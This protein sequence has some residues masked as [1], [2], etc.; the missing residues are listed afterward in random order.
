MMTKETADTVTSL[1]F[2]SKELSTK[3]WDRLN[4]LP[5]EI[6]NDLVKT[7]EGVLD[8][9]DAALTFLDGVE[10]DKYFDEDY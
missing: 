8:R 5:E 4:T 6:D 1:R 3:A 10:P 7:L 2:K 9:I